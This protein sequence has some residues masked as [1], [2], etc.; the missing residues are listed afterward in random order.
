MKHPK[1][2]PGKDSRLQPGSN[3]V[4]D[5]FRYDISDPAPAMAEIVRSWGLDPDSFIGQTAD[6]KLQ[7][8]GPDESN[9]I[10]GPAV[11]APTSGHMPTVRTSDPYVGM[12][13]SISPRKK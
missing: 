9:G 13:E 7:F 8:N 2:R 12:S 3:S 1:V 6:G 10:S 5:N 4:T 11:P